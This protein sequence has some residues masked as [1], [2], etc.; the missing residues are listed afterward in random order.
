[1]GLTLS[2]V[3]ALTALSRRKQGFDSP[4]ERQAQNKRSLL[5]GYQKIWRRFC[6]AVPLRISHQSLDT[7]FGRCG[8][9]QR[10]GLRVES[11]CRAFRDRVRKSQVSHPRTVAFAGNRG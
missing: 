5:N 1:M 2:L 8:G 7:C 11:E 9:D 4:W 6:D 10:H 3:V